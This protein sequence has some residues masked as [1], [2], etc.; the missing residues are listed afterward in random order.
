VHEQAGKA[1]AERPAGPAQP[2]QDR[3]RRRARG[4]PGRGRQQVTPLPAPPHSAGRGLHRSSTEVQQ[5]PPQPPARAAMNS[6]S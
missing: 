2:A 1:R 3:Q 4:A 6:R 5:R